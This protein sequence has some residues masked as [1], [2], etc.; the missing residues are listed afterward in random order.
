MATIEDRLA[1][2]EDAIMALGVAV[3]DG[4]PERLRVKVDP[5]ASQA[6]NRYLQ[7]MSAILAERG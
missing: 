2:L 7:S 6:A 1:R 5:S 4:N 3:S